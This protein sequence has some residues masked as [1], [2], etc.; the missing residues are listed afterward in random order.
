MLDH[1]YV[2]FYLINII[3]LYFQILIKLTV[4]NK[5][6]TRIY[7]PIGVLNIQH[8]ISIQQII[9]SGSTKANLYF[10]YLYILPKRVNENDSNK[11]TSARY[12]VHFYSSIV[13]NTEICGIIV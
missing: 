6:L 5:S 7:Y 11:T 2:I 4:F 13:Q 10:I 8:F 3:E 12:P 9:V 1:P